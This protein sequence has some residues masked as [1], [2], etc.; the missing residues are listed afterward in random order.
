[1]GLHKHDEEHRVQNSLYAGFVSVLNGG[2]LN[3][4]KL[5]GNTR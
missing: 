4:Q 1:M 2:L 5:T 3:S